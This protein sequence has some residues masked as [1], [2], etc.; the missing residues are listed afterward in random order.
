MDLRKSNPGFGNLH[1]QG[2]IEAGL[3]I[4]SGAAV[5]PFETIAKDF[6]F[7]MVLTRVRATR[8]NISGKK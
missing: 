1:G 3:L 2:R 7:Q 5:V 8:G 4:F 6:C